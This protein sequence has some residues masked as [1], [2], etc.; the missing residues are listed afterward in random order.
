M[1][2]LIFVFSFFAQAAAPAQLRPLAINEQVIRRDLAHILK[3]AKLPTDTLGVV[4]NAGSSNSVR[5][6]CQKKP[7]ALQ[8]TTTEAEKSATF[9]LDLMRMRG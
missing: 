5:F 2:I 4:W 7:W 6:N 1:F 9:L 3:E 8:V